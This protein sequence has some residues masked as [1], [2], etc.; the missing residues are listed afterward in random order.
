M[1]LFGDSPSSSTSKPVQPSNTGMDILGDLFG[2]ASIAL[3]TSTSSTAA[4]MDDLFGSS[5]PTT[6]ETKSYTCYSKNNLL[7]VLTPTRVGNTAT[8]NINAVFSNSGS[9]DVSDLGFQ[10]AVPK[11]LKLTM[12]PPSS[13]TVGIGGKESQALR[14]ENPGKANIRLRLKIGYEAGGERVDEIVEF[15]SFD[16]SLWA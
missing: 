3:V 16:A 6:P 8:I 11:S 7:I 13:T 12:D 1:G 14:I 4:S 5:A 15:S 2:G 10:V 9:G